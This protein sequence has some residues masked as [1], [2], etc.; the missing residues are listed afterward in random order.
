MGHNTFDSVTNMFKQAFLFR[1][2]KN[3]NI[4]L[5]VL[6]VIIT[7]PFLLTALVFFILY[8][9]INFSFELIKSPADYLLSLTKNVGNDVKHATQAVVYFVGFPTAFLLY[10]V[11]AFLVPLLFIAYFLINCCVYCFTLGDIKFNPYLD[12]VVEREYSLEDEKMY[13]LT[14]SII[15][16]LL[17]LLF[18]AGFLTCLILSLNANNDYQLLRNLMVI[19]IFKYIS[20][21]LYCLMFAISGIFY[22]PNLLQPVLKAENPEETEEIIGDD[23]SSAT[24][25]KSNFIVSFFKDAIAFRSKGTF[26]LNV[27]LLCLMVGFAIT[28]LACSIPNSVDY[29]GSSGGK[30]VTLAYSLK[31]HWSFN[32]II[33][34]MVLSCIAPIYFLFNKKIPKAIN[35]IFYLSIGILAFATLGCTFD[36][37]SMF[38]NMT[39]KWHIYGNAIVMWISLGLTGVS[40][41]IKGIISC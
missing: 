8:H 2:Y 36:F 11:M 30:T 41:I 37:Y 29:F 9:I 1:K 6:Y 25:E 17:S 20:M 31:N 35:A 39:N 3:I 32:M 33:V 21:I 13:R 12:H 4:V 10:T 38:F 5:A 14:P 23:E 24:N 27:V 19:N 26:V 28:A 40:S 22:N 18:F 15:H 34:T 7:I 16:C